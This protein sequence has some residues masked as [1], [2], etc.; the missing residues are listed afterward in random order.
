MRRA[1]QQPRGSVDDVQMGMPREQR[2]AAAP[3]DPWAQTLRR[4]GPVQTAR[5]LNVNQAQA[6]RNGWVN[7][8]AGIVPQGVR[9]GT[10]GR[11]VV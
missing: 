5:L 2:C 7:R 9:R 6:G 8:Y 3:V 10:D 11:W 1:Q 4:A